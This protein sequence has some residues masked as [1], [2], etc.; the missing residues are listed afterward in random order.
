MSL[1]SFAIVVCVLLLLPALAAQQ[2]A[3][4]RAHAGPDPYTQ[5]DP[6][7][8]KKAGYESLGPFPFGTGHDT[9]A[10]TDLLGTE[11]LVW[12]ETAHFRIGCA[13]SRLALRNDEPWREEWN[14]SVRAELKR[15]ATRLPRVKVD[16]KELDPWLRAHLIAQRVEDL[17]AQVLKNFGL[18]EF[19][20]PVAPD[21]PA[22]PESYR[23]QGRHLGMREK[24]TVLLLQKASS[25]GRYTRSY[26]G[27]EITDP[28][29]WQDIPFGCL[30]FGASEETANGLFRHDFALH[31]HLY[32][33]L[34]HNLYTGYRSFGHD[35]PPWL[36]TGL[37]HWH[38]RGVTPRFPTFDRKDD[39]D[40]EMR[41][42]FWEWDKRVVGLLRNNAFEPVPALLARTN[43]GA[44][45]LE[46]HMQS[47]A[48]VDFLVRDHRPGLFQFVHRMK[49]PFHRQ[50]KTPTE[51]EMQARQADS[52]QAALGMDAA[53]LEEAWRKSVVGGKGRK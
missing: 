16:V 34:A 48:L 29:R 37:A 49:D 14:A 8:L 10:V 21:D 19:H 32:F 45:D 52:L 13:L 27:R 36:V 23:G 50:R 38:S 9:R 44:F 4:V 42:D 25:H 7:A 15:L 3:T 2:P 12:I 31:C 41:S 11:P 18:K 6:A 22:V 30:Y 35:L 46:Q 33:N 43:A 17:Y 53:R 5:G 20:F 28:I 39:K 51:A 24:F 40:R 1:Q 47:W 26:Q